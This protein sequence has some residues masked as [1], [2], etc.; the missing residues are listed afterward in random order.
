VENGR[1]G[2]QSLSGIAIYIEGGGDSTDSKAAIRRGMATFLAAIRDRARALRW[3]WKVVPCG[4]R[5]AAWEAFQ[6]EV[7]QNPEV[8]NV[9]LVDSED[10][11]IGR[12]NHHLHVR[13]GWDLHPDDAK[14]LRQ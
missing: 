2:G 6:H 9:L 13:D 8:F 7:E 3:N 5:V 12:A 1:T 10:P 4:S 11:V 14:S